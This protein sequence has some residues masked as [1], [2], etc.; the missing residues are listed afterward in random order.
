MIL[1]FLVLR[2]R[3]MFVRSL[4]TLLILPSAVGV[5]LGALLSLSACGKK[6]ELQPPPQPVNAGQT[7]DPQ[8]KPLAQAQ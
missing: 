8:A 3:E 5:L 1:R 2:Y 4:L 6:G 7:A